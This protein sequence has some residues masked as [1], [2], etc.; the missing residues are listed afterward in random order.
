MYGSCFRILSSDIK[1]S[2]HFQ[3]ILLLEYD[4]FII[5]YYKV[6]VQRFLLSK[7]LAINNFWL[8]T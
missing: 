5:H 7:T 2:C 8:T 1:L 6:I 4:V 3:E